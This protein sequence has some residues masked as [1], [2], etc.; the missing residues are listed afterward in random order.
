MKKLILNIKNKLKNYDY[1]SDKDLL[2]LISD[3]KFLEEE[4][5]NNFKSSLVE[6]F[7]KINTILE[8][9]FHDDTL[10]KKDVFILLQEIMY[11]DKVL[12]TSVT[13]NKE[14]KKDS[15]SGSTIGNVIA[16]V[17]LTA[18]GFAVGAAILDSSRSTES[19]ENSNILTIAYYLSKYDHDSLFDNSISATKAIEIIAN[20]VNVKPNT[21][22]NKRDYFDA[23]L[24]LKNIETKSGRKGYQ[25]AN[26]TK[27]YELIIDKY[28]DL[29]KEE[30]KSK[31]L[32]ILN[33]YKK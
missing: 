33:S 19:L 2:S 13:P 26:L 32:E 18:L 4:I 24:S 8:S 20:E 1:D 27:Q 25:N 21:L 7:K 23:F 29:S 5:E 16:G 28:I 11:I 6:N 15:D 14:I 31:V 30:V 3:F 9:A 10:E 22:R 12:N 17:A